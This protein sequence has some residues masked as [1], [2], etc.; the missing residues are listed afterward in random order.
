M[1]HREVNVSVHQAMA[2]CFFTKV[3]IAS[4]YDGATPS[5]CPESSPHPG[6]PTLDAG[7]KKF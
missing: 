7:Q 2:Q 3:V 4:S 6:V 1:T 5:E